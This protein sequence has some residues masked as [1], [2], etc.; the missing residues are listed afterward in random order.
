MGGHTA[1]MTEICTQMFGEKNLEGTDHLEDKGM[2]GRIILNLIFLGY[3]AQ[4]SVPCGAHI[5]MLINFHLFL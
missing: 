1:S 4:S 5:N 2:I 3:P